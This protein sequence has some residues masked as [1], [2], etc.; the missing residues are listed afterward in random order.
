[1]YL[2]RKTLTSLVG[3]CKSKVITIRGIDDFEIVNSFAWALYRT[4]IIP[5]SEGLR[6]PPRIVRKQEIKSRIRVYRHN[7]LCRLRKSSYIYRPVYRHLWSQAEA[8]LDKFTGSNPWNECLTIWPIG[9]LSWRK[10][11]PNS[12]QN[13]TDILNSPKCFS[14]SA[15]GPGIPQEYG[16]FVDMM[17]R[18]L[19]WRSFADSMD[20]FVKTLT[21]L[22]V[23]QFH[24]DMNQAY[25]LLGSWALSCT[26]GPTCLQ[27]IS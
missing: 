10:I 26:C 27:V 13:P 14:S 7:G 5:A 22:L 6:F 21:V 1:M 25:T 20:E 24:K 2:S 16:N 9:A 15:F 3:M 19:R 17:W 4:H 23:N 18:A 11:R 8:Y 12:M